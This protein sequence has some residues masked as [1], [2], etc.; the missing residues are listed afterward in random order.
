MLMEK[1][2]T[3]LRAV[4]DE[5]YRNFYMQRLVT[6]IP[7]REARADA[8]A[9]K[10][11]VYDGPTS[12]EIAANARTLSEDSYVMQENVITPVQ[13]VEIRDFLSN[14]RFHDPYRKELGE[15]V[16]PDNIPAGTFVAH[17]AADVLPRAPHVLNI[18][19]RPD[20]LGVV[21]SMLGAKPTISCL[22]SWWSVPSGVGVAQQ[23][24]NFH[25]DV[26]DWRFVKLF[27]YLT[28]V[29]EESGPHVL[30][31]GSHK[32]NA[33]TEI[34]RFGDEEVA[35]TFGADKQVRFTGP[36]GSCFLEN[37]YDIHRGYP[38]VSKPR[39]IF[40]VLYSLRPV[41]Y[42]PKSPICTLGQ[43]GVPADI[44]PY[45]NRVYCRAG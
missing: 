40:Q 24:E 9:A 19:N 39:L 22:Q 26:D 21:A 3:R 44:D 42:G 37:T 34:R 20:I 1:I 31:K 45:I 23:A 5:R 29:D 15:F 13:V 6:D 11:P 10:L 36:A 35:D 2:N 16:A 8:V 33:L 30:V 7:T 25:R 14:V 43:D 32:V 28:D 12:P 41:I 17:V 38:P 4:V 18:A 27:I